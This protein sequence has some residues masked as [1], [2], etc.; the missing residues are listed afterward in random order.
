[1]NESVRTA[2]MADVTGMDIADHTRP[3]GR[4]HPLEHVK[5]APRWLGPVMDTLGPP[6]HWLTGVHIIARE[7][8]E[9]VQKAGWTLDE[10]VSF[11]GA[12]LFLR[13]EARTPAGDSTSDTEQ[14]ISLEDDA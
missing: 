6:V 9:N 7:T 13:I 4:L 1:M 11:T 5:A 14:Q 3:G 8:A 2:K 10:V 12:D